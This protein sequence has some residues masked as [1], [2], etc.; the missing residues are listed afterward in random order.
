MV[1]W[2]DGLSAET[3][4]AIYTTVA[5]PLL[6]G[7]AGWFA[8]LRKAARQRAELLTFL[9][10]L[11]PAGKA[12]LAEFLADGQHTKIG[13]VFDGT[14]AQLVRMGLLVQGEAVQAFDRERR[15][16]TIPLRVWAL[17]P[18]WRRTDPEF[19]SLVAALE[20]DPRPDNPSDHG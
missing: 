16:Y 4:L 11:G 20:H 12:T 2:L 7:F 18:K 14:L 1:E 15:F 9:R 19:A 5:A 6:G 3:L 10:G 8:A 13:S 17:L